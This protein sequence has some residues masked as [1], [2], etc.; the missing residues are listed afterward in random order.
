MVYLSNLSRTSNTPKFRFLKIGP[1]RNPKNRFFP[2]I[3]SKNEF[4]T[5]KNRKKSEEYDAIGPVKKF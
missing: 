3:F 1:N 4:D 5:S 2:E